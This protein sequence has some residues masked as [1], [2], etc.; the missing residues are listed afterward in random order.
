M[1]PDRISIP[2]G[3]A[4]LLAALPSVLFSQN[5]RDI[6]KR[7]D[8][9]MRGES[10]YSEFTMT[11]IKPEWQRSMSMKS[12]SLEPDLAL[13]YVLEPARDKGTVT[14]KR[15]NEVWN[16]LPSVQKVIKIPPSMMLQSWMGSDFTNDD[17][18]RA[19]SIIDDYTHT[20]LG[21]EMYDGRECYKIALVPKPDAG[22][23]W[24]KVIIWISAG[25]YLEL[26]TEYYDED[27]VLV[28]TFYGSKVTRFGDRML[29]AHWEMVPADKPGN[30]TVLE[31]TVLRFNI[32]IGRDFFSLQNMSRV[33]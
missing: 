26:K 19:S 28:K 27:G 29:P 23:V 3:V 31:Y 20:L 33:H 30:R 4:L 11:I 7:A 8:E 6:V 16:W 14:L 15:G 2:A 21:K 13:V 25:E 9:L 12:W 10:S 32:R 1:K 5:A 17:L 22:I 24:G 18:V